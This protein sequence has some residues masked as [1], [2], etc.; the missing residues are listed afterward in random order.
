MELLHA[1]DFDDVRTGAA[2]TGAHGV[3]KVGQV[4]HVGL[5]G[6]VF[7]DSSALGQDCG[8]HDVH[9]RAHRLHIQID[10][11]AHQ[12]LLGGGNDLAADGLD[13][14][15][16]GLK[17]LDMLVNGAGAEITA[18]G[19]GYLSPTK[20]P[21]Q[22]A[23]EVVAGTDPPC[24]VKGRPGLPHVATVK[25]PGTGIHLG[26]CRPHGDEDIDQVMDIGDIRDVF[27]STFSVDQQC[28][29]D[30]GDR[31]VFRAADRDRSSQRFA[32]ADNILGHKTAPLPYSPTSSI[33]C[34]G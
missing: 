4:D 32:A 29:R 16:Q 8:N 3:E 11:V 22:R 20:T 21:Q 1:F 6:C 18:A 31:C 27:Y 23:N 7:N 13:G 33:P 15:A 2:D 26:H 28:C 34:L 19:H 24:L 10:A 30:N 17:A 5:L 9:R 25:I 12:T 14:A